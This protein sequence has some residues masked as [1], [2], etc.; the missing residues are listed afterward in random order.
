[1]IDPNRKAIVTGASGWLGQNLVRALRRG[2]PEVPSL[3]VG[4]EREIRCLVNSAHDGEVINALECGVITRLGDLT[5]PESLLPLFEDAEGAT[6]FHCAGVIHPNRKS[7]FQAVNCGGTRAMLEGARRAGARR[8]AYI[9]S[10]S[11]IGCNETPE[12][13]FDETAPYNPYMGYGESKRRA[14]ELV[15]EAGANGIET[16]IIRPPWFYGPGQPDRQ[17]KFFQMI[18]EGK[19]PLVGDGTNRR[20]MAYVDNICQGLL[21]C[22]ARD[23]AAGEIYWIAD[24]RPYPMREIIDTVASVLREDFGLEVKPGYFKLPGFVS[25][26]ALLCDKAIQGIGLYQTKIHV[27]SEMN[28]TIA[29]D[30]TKAKNELGYQPTIALR[31]GMRRSIEELLSRGLEI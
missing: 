3:S 26:V 22:E 16:V 13:T 17:T 30:I 28:K 20:S 11:P 31:E 8:F 23:N 25:E 9:S 7:E 15:I 19:G 2:L 21:L 14:E 27:L 5:A 12:S 6:V 24:E 29:C 1:M 10:N 4:S 18:K